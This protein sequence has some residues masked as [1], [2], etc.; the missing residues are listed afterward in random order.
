MKIT[1]RSFFS[2]VMRIVCYLFFSRTLITARIK[3]DSHTLIAG[4]TGSGKSKLDEMIFT[5]LQRR[6]ARKRNC[7]MVFVDI[8]G[9]TARTLLNS[10]HNRDRDRLVYISSAINR[11]AKTD[12]PYSAVINFFEVPEDSIEAK[13][14]YA[15]E[16]AEALTELLASSDNSFNTIS[17]N[18][19]TLLKATIFTVMCSP[20]PSL[21]TLARFFLDKDGQNADLLDLGRNSPIQTYRE[22]FMYDWNHST[23][24][25]SKA[26]IRNRLLFF[27]ADPMLA[28]M[29]NG[30]STVNLEQCLNDGKVV[31]INVPKAAGRFTS[32]V[33]SR[34]AIA[35]I[36][37][38]MLRRDTLE[39]KD[40]KPCYLFLDEFQAM[41]TNSLV[42][43]LAECRKYG[44]NLVLATQSIHSL[45]KQVRTA[46]LVNT[47]IKMVGILDHEG[48]S[49][50][51][52][53]LDVPMEKLN[54]LEPL[55]FMVRKND[56]KHTAFKF[57]VPILA[58]RFF[59]S[60]DERK[61]LLDYLVYRSGIYKKITPSS[62]APQLSHSD[63]QLKKETKS[64]KAT[65]DLFDDNLKPHFS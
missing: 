14:I 61:D 29:I 62:P 8:H 39:R 41:I 4:K 27:I 58:K 34:L 42:S 47:G 32:N 54:T 51:S 20:D 26:A 63:D 2:R 57:R 55:H 35:F 1:S 46:V 22:Y 64:A 59:L 3:F 6:S 30:R 50:F 12:E 15:N 36:H 43:S 13:A 37:A 21:A 17:V 44:L 25:L 10:V 56:G 28:P 38:I 19:S 11:E 65:D 40:R 33:L 23:L 45:D 16:I 18:M 9:D 49:L 5:D 52:K 60:K 24:T 7:A 53:E 31:I 48:K